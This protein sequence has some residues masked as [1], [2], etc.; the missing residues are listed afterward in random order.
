MKRW[1]SHTS[2]AV[3][4]ILATLSSVAKSTNQ[5]GES[6]TTTTFKDD[7][8]TTAFWDTGAKALRMNTQKQ[9]LR[10]INVG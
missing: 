1:V 3:V 5:Y 2:V 9:T 8:N 4:L 6:F 7:A 10:I